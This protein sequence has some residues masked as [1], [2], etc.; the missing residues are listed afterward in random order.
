MQRRA[1]LQAAALGLTTGFAGC[2]G[3]TDGSTQ[4]DTA[5]ATETASPTATQEPTPRENPPPVD[6]SVSM[7]L[8]PRKYLGE[9]E[10]PG[11]ATSVSTLIDWE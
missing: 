4:T 5:T 11:S 10:T 7:L 6:P 2:N 3:L 8:L 1:Y 9:P